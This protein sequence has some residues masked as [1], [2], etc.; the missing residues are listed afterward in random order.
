MSVSSASLSS[1]TTSADAGPSKVPVPTASE[2]LALLAKLPS[3]FPL[4]PTPSSTLDT[5]DPS[6][7]AKPRRA[8]PQGKQPRSFG[9]IAQSCAA[10]ALLKQAMLESVW[11]VLGGD[12][13]RVGERE[14]LEE[15]LLVEGEAGRV[16]REVEEKVE[17]AR[18]R[19]ETGGAE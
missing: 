8:P 13:R 1:V 11:G 19:I 7:A 18:E 3:D 15:V 10:H 16:L 9:R 17:Q 6:A 14:R 5:L 2:L 12:E 4:P